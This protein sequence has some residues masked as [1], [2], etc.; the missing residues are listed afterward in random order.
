MNAYATVVLKQG[1]QIC[2]DQNASSNKDALF[3][4]LSEFRESDEAV[5]VV[6]L[7]SLISVSNPRPLPILHRRRV[8][9][10]WAMTHRPPI[11]RAGDFVLDCICVVNSAI[12]CRG[13]SVTVSDKV[14]LTRNLD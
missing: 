1:D 7:Q 12:A 9:C 14:D 13:S 10:E 6:R 11:N 8:L 4:M 2:R 5:V 3:A